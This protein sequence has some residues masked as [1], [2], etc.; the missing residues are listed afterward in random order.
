MSV[1]EAP[2]ILIELKLLY[3]SHKTPIQSSESFE[4]ESSVDEGFQMN[5]R[6]ETPATISRAAD[7]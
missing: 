3:S 4:Y 6:R 2:L 7:F 5:S 1:W